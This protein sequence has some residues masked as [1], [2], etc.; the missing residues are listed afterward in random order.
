MDGGSNAGFALN[1]DE[2]HRLV[3]EHRNDV[4]LSLVVG[5]LLLTV[6]V[7]GLFYPLFYHVFKFQAPSAIRWAY[8]T[9][10]LV[11]LGVFHWLCWAWLLLGLLKSYWVWLIWFLL[12]CA[13]AASFAL[14][15][16]RRYA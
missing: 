12:V 15:P 16:K 8:L 10:F 11:A 7:Q 1:L 14:I 2:I 6:G 9:A 3:V 5:F 4:T 13:V